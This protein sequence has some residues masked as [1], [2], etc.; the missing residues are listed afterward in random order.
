MDGDLRLS[1]SELTEHALDV[2]RAALAIGIVPGDRAA[3]W[4]PNS[5]AWVVAALGTVGAG[6]VLVP[7]NTRFKGKEAAHILRKSGARVLFTV[8][9]FLG[10]DYPAMLD[11]EDLPDLDRIVLLHDSSAGAAE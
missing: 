2:T 8:E 4:A 1:F 9:N 5:A 6:A 11:E 7:I 10:V 3:I